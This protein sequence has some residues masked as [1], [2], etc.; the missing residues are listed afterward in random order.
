MV[1]GL[2]DASMVMLN[3][4]D[5]RNVDMLFDNG[6]N[7]DAACESCH[8]QYWYPD[9]EHHAPPPS[10]AEKA[11]NEIADAAD[12]DPAARATGNDRR[13]RRSPG[14]L[15]GN[16]VIRMG[17]D[18]KCADINRGKQVVQEEFAL[19]GRRQPRQRVREARGR[20]SP[21]PRCP[22]SRW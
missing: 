16:A 3:A 9:P 21:R 19:Q 11:L 5:A 10:E 20:S 4:V 6:G 17:M 8:R 15:P 18:P 1:H 22:P 12:D 13:T 14:K 2:H 7:L